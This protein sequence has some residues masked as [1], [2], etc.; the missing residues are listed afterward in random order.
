M[1]IID[2]FL[3]LLWSSELGRCDREFRPSL[4]EDAHYMPNRAERV[5]LL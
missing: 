1:P 3:V 2:E 4:R 5:H